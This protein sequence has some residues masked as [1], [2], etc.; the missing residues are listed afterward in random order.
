MMEQ[1][2]A[3]ALGLFLIQ[4]YAIHQDRGRFDQDENDPADIS[5]RTIAP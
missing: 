4:R 2:R 5:R 1:H 3:S